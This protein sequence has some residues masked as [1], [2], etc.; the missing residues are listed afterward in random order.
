MGKHNDKLKYGLSN[1]DYNNNFKTK[2]KLGKHIKN[3]K[4]I[5]CDKNHQV[6]V[7]KRKCGSG[8]KFYIGKT[9][10]CFKICHSQHS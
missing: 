8:D 1:E 10:T 5:K 2:I 7:Y 4:L 9:F 3:K 6:R